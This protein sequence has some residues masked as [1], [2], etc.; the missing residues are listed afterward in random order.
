MIASGVPILDA[1]E[2]T[3]ARLHDLLKVRILME[4]LDGPIDANVSLASQI[5][6]VPG[7]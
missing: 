1:L 3:D 4:R 6:T 5:E 2:I 7:Y